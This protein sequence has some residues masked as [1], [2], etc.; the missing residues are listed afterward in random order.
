MR[1]K[2]YTPNT[3]HWS[4]CGDLIVRGHKI[5]IAQKYEALAEEAHTSGDM[6][7]YHVF[8]NHREH[9]MKKDIDTE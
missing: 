9:W 8:L 7:R 1:R 6:H 5:Q 4:T 3:Q 2:Q